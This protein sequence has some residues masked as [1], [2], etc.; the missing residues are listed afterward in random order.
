MKEGVSTSSSS[1]REGLK[2]NGGEKPKAKGQVQTNVGLFYVSNIN[3]I[4]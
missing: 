3:I 2:R 4:L 1:R